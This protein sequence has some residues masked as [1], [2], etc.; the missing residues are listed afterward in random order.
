MWLESNERVS[1]QGVELFAFCP[2]GLRIA[3]YFS[4]LAP[5][6]T[7]YGCTDLRI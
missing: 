3:D 2:S 7:V 6:Y 5:A 1:P 4:A